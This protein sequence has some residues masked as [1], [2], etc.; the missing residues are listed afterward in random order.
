MLRAKNRN[1][2]HLWLLIFRKIPFIQATG[3]AKSTFNMI[4][5]IRE[6]P[7]RA[8]KVYYATQQI[9][10]PLQVPYLGMGSSYFATLAL[11]Y[12]GVPIQ[13]FPA[14]DYFHYLRPTSV[15]DLGVLISQSGRSSEVL[16]CR[17][18]FRRFYAITNEIKSPLC[19]STSLERLFPLMAGKEDHSSTKTYINTLLTLYNGLKV[20]PYP[21][22]RLLREKAAEYESWGNE[23]AGMLHSLISG[24][25]YKGCYI[26]GSG[27]N[28]ATAQKAALVLSEATKHPFIAMSTAQYDHGPKETALDSAVIVILS[29]GPDAERTRRLFELVRNAGARVF[30]FQEQ[31]VDAALSPIV[32]IMP[33]NYMAYYLARLLNIT[34]TFTVGK[35]VTET[36]PET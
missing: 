19:V 10:L 27:P 22:M 8:E 33:F 25:N 1:S 30:Y 35:K 29:K 20:D 15:S 2:R 4:Q 34:R 28:L 6:I 7:D 36:D 5:E 23:M 26:I 16:W 17:D 32:S 9:T 11:Y 12:Q 21:A 18:L 14:S 3:R 24:G 13:P 31:E